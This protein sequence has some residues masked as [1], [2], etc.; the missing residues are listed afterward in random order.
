MCNSGS[1]SLQ[2]VKV[3]VGIQIALEA[4]LVFALYRIYSIIPDQV[5]N[6]HE[7]LRHLYIGFRGNL[8]Y[9]F[10]V[11]AMIL[12]T[13]CTLVFFRKTHAHVLVIF[14]LTNSLFLIAILAFWWALAP[15]FQSSVFVGWREKVSHEKVSDN[16]P[17]TPADD[18]P[19]TPLQ[20]PEGKSTQ[21]PGLAP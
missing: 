11:V 13:S 9:P 19:F 4:L 10:W 18:S 8:L 2:A 21:K 7:E 14:G 15:W 16:T 20:P 1:M 6:F 3:V 5:F 17:P 12:A